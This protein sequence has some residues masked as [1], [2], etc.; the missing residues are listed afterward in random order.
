[1][2]RA[3][4]FSFLAAAC[5]SLAPCEARADWPH[6]PY[7]GGVG[8]CTAAGSQETPAA[9]ADGSGGTFV[10]WTSMSQGGV[11][12]Q[13]LDARGNALWAA[14]GVPI[15]VNEANHATLVLDGAG[16]VV[17][18]WED[19]RV[20]GKSLMY[21]QRLNAAGT[22]MWTANGVLLMSAGSGPSRPYATG[23]RITSDGA[24][25]AI[26]TWMQTLSDISPNVVR[27]QRV[28][29]AGVRQWGSNG[30]GLSSLTGEQIDP[31]IASDGAGGA[32]V[33]WT[34]Q[35]T[36]LNLYAQR[37]NASG[38]AQWVANGI[39]VAVPFGGSGQ[40]HASIAADGAGG[41]LLAWA[42]ARSEGG[43]FT[44]LWAQLL[45]SA[46][47][48]L[49]G[50]SG[51]AVCE[52]AASQADPAL[53]PDGAGGAFIAWSD[54]RGGYNYSDVY[55]QHVLANGTHA[56]T[57]NGVAIAVSFADKFQTCVAADGAG[58][59]IVAWTDLA[60]VYGDIRARRVTST[61][62]LVPAAGPAAVA[63]ALEQQVTPAIAADAMGGAVVVW[64]DYRSSNNDILAQR[65]D[66]S[67]VLGDPSARITRVRDTA[68]DQGGK[69]K[70][71]WSAS[72]VDDA[73]APATFDYQLY[74][75]VGAGAWTLATTIP[76]GP[77]A[78]YSAVVATAADSGASNPYTQ[79]KVRARTGPAVA[80]YFWDSPVDSGY[81]VDNLAPQPVHELAGRFA[82]GVTRLSWTPGSEPD[83]AGY[84]VYRGASADFAT[85]PQSQV[86]TTRESGW[87]DDAGTAWIYK[88][89]AVDAHGNESP[90][91]A[92]TPDAEVGAAQVAGV[93]MSAPRPNPARDAST[94][95]FALPR[96]GRAALVIC[97]V[98]GR[99]VQELGGAGAGPGEH[100]LVWDLRDASGARVS[101]GL[102]FAR[103]VV[104]GAV[105]A[106]GRVV[107]VR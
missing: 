20:S 16:G 105:R 104:D 18:A 19:L 60:D 84:R 12:V 22:P 52:E 87:T 71:S 78:E 106:S 99:R 9:I 67:G 102:Y 76:A 94:I 31:V 41:A 23:S 98:S 46:G 90:A 62:A 96:A 36:D 3:L 33:A 14:D 58:G 107:V 66:A 56:W 30:I 57:A 34:E 40:Y 11:Y 63:S 26:L 51:N 25:G 73:F 1:M 53:V 64:A 74:K 65:F 27:A 35:R 86:A 70:V 50:F 29:A 7:S 44:D 68:G 91:I 81:S 21:A 75:R 97:D 100:V 79:F 37:L 89:T 48:R 59:M 55:G 80:D 82:D 103:L 43:T 61:G 24:A 13:H 45:D 69:V 95:R 15:N 10:A 88:V 49:W 28:S 6:D 39:N 54:H 72:F 47:N 93:V 92:F 77:L 38:V 5:V 42:D 83:L 8:V 17:V 32:Y 4:V 85:S 2:I 101:A